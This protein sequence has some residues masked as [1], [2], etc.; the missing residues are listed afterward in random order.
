MQYLNK[1]KNTLNESSLAL[2]DDVKNS[3]L[4]ASLHKSIKNIINY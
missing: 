3:K 2:H 4:I 1:I